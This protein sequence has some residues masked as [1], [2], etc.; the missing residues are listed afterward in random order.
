MTLDELKARNDL[1]PE[2]KAEI[3]LEQSVGS[4][5]YKEHLNAD[6][7]VSG[8]WASW[9]DFSYN[10]APAIA[11]NTFD[12]LTTLA[13]IAVFGIV[14]VIGFIAYKKYIK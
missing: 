13:K 8:F 9:L 3:W 10:K 4:D 14:A 12:K 6:S 11:K 1:T 2:Q 5:Y 7:G